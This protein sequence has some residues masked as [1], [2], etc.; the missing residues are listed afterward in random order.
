MQGLTPHQLA[1]QHAA[2]HAAAT[3]H[4][5]GVL[6]MDRVASHLLGGGAAG[7]LQQPPT[8]LPPS[9][10]IPPLPSPQQPAP[11]PATAAPPPPGT[12]RLDIEVPEGANV[13]DRL[14]FNTAAGQFSLVVPTGAAPGKKMM[15]TMP[16]PANFQS[17]QQLA[18]SSLRINGNLPAP[19]HTPEQFAMSKAHRQIVEAHWNRFS[20]HEKVQANLALDLTA[21]KPRGEAVALRPWGFWNIPTTR[22]DVAAAAEWPACAA[23][24]IQTSTFRFLGARWELALEVTPRAWALVDDIGGEGGPASKRDVVFSVVLRRPRATEAGEPLAPLS[25]W[26]HLELADRWSHSQRANSGPSPNPDPNPDP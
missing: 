10:P 13:G 23:R 8:G 24:S 19:K 7:M 26:A 11:A 21:Y 6:S 22:Q 9:P 4:A 3:Q 5:A 18:I 15:V 12:V 17:H 2:Q 25:F 14:T 20:A 16:V 1:Q